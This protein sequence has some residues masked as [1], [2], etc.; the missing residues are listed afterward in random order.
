MFIQHLFDFLAQEWMRYR[1]PVGRSWQK[2][3][4]VIVNCELPLHWEKRGA[5][6]DFEES[7]RNQKYNQSNS[8]HDVNLRPG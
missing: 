2:V 8:L 5:Q 3:G 7:E 4:Y 1:R 6:V